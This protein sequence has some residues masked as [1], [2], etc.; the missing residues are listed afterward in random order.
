MTQIS[1]NSI[2]FNANLANIHIV[3]K[4]IEEICDTYNIFNNFFGN[5]L[6]AV[7]E[8][9]ENAI[10]HGNNNDPET[11][12]TV[13]FQNKPAGLYFTVSDEGKGFDTN[14]LPD[15][16]DTNNSGSEGRGL[17]LIK[18]LADEVSF[19][20]NGS[21]VHLLFKI[22]SINHELMI[23]RKKEISNYFSGKP[24]QASTKPSS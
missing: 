13:S 12:V 23:K 3:E 5:I 16:T 14:N 19:D 1:N 7:S 4:F 17:F 9:V 21:T 20:N 22:A 11:T 8:A 15:P 18:S 6:I 24:V 10:I 2:A